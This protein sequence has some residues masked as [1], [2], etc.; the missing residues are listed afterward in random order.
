MSSGEAPP[1][2]P[3]SRAEDIC[4]RAEFFDSGRAVATGPTPWVAS[5]LPSARGTASASPL[6][7]FRSSITRPACAASY[8]SPPR[9]PSTAQGLAL[10]AV[11]FCQHRIRLSVAPSSHLLSSAGLSRRIP[12]T[13][14]SSG[15][16]PAGGRPPPNRAPQARSGGGKS[17]EH[18]WGQRVR[19][20]KPMKAAHIAG[21]SQH[22]T[23]Y[24][25]AWRSRPR[26]DQARRAATGPNPQVLQERP[27]S[28]PAQSTILRSN[29]TCQTPPSWGQV[30]RFSPTSWGQPIARVMGPPAR[31]MP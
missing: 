28:G 29:P 5:V 16:A 20:T 23:A 21:I 25:V 30:L 12:P 14:P 9:S 11:D 15:Y 7:L 19:H 6:G 10:L 27:K 4:E 24:L 8:A 18:R 3:G 31:C 2:S 13:R 26:P 17:R 1:R 22:A